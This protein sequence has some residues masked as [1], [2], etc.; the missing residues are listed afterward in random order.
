[1]EVL[2][3]MRAYSG[4]PEGIEPL[5]KKEG[6][7]TKNIRCCVSGDMD[8]DGDFCSAWVLF[9]DKGL[10][11]AT[12]TEDVKRIKGAKRLETKYTLRTLESIPIG[13]IDR[14]KTEKYVSTAALIAEMNGDDSLIIKFSIGNLPGFE[15]FARAFDAQKKGESVETVIKGFK[16]AQYCPKCGAEMDEPD[17]S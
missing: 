1:M 3:Q 12:G 11:I 7:D 8:R 13:D 15:D 9:D 2:T 17:E 4:V 16:G 14:L 10:Y 6:L 5:L